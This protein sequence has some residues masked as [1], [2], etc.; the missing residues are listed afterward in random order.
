MMK[1]SLY[2]EQLAAKGLRVT[3]ARTLVLKLLDQASWPMTVDEIYL[4]IKKMN[5]NITLSTVYR[6]METLSSNSLIVKTAILD[7][8][9]SRYEYNRM[10][11]KHH[12]ICT[13]CN[14]IVPVK[15]CP[16][17]QYAKNICD[18]NGFKQTGHRLEI[19]GICA[20]CMDNL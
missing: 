10:E 11:H 6:T 3:K 16:L 9:R 18:E 20:G 13:S 2:S 12:L 17:D 8:S 14:K 15:G 4:G 19:Y 1:E 5:L 7:D